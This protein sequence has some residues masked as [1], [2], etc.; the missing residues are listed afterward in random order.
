MKQKAFAAQVS[1]EDI[2]AGAES[3]GMELDEHIGH[4]LT[5]LQGAADDLGL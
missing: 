2:C 4:V 3:L 5:A 1:R